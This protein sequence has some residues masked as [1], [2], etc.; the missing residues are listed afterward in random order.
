LDIEGYRSVGGE[1]EGHRG[2]RSDRVARIAQCQAEH[3]FVS[4]LFFVLVTFC[5][6]SGVIVTPRESRGTS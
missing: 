4:F 3:R 6:L 2:E 1:T 5:D